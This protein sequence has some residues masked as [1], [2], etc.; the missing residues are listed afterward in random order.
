MKVGYLDDNVAH[1]GVENDL[2]C[3]GIRHSREL[4]MQ[5]QNATHLRMED[6][7]QLVAV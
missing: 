6:D 4:G 2:R 7:V 5:T 3:L 1:G